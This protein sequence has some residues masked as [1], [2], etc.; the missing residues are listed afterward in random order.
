MLHAATRT[1]RGLTLSAAVQ[2][3]YT[4]PPPKGSWGP[5]YLTALCLEPMLQNAL[6]TECARY[7]MHSLQNALATE[8]TAT[9]CTRYNVS[10]AWENNFGE[11]TIRLGLE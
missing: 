3:T 5:L 9:E 10:P 7:R 6:A 4:P 2:H 8:C 1:S 11:A